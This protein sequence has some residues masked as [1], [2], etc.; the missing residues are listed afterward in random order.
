MKQICVHFLIILLIV[1]QSLFSFEREQD[2]PRM[3][4]NEQQLMLHFIQGKQFFKQSNYQKAK[5]EF[6]RVVEINSKYKPAYSYLERIQD[7][8]IEEMQS[9]QKRYSRMDRAMKMAE[10][11]ERSR[12]PTQVDLFYQLTNSEQRKLDAYVGDN[13]FSKMIQD[14]RLTVLNKAK[15]IKKDIDIVLQNRRQD[16]VM[17]SLSDQTKPFLVR[18][19]EE[20]IT[21]APGM[22]ERVAQVESVQEEVDLSFYYNRKKKIQ[23][24]YKRG[25]MYYKQRDFFEAKKHF[26]QVLKLEPGYK[27]AQDYYESSKSQLVLTEIQRRKAKKH[28]RKPGHLNRKIRMQEPIENVSERRMIEE[29][30]QVAKQMSRSFH[31]REGALLTGNK[32]KLIV[33]GITSYKNKDY[34][35][36]LDIFE[37]ILRFD[38]KDKKA[39]VYRQKILEI[40]NDKEDAVLEAMERARIAA[41]HEHIATQTDRRTLAHR[42]E[43]IHQ[44]D[45]VEEAVVDRK[46]RIIDL[47]AKGKTY[48]RKKKYMQALEYFRE[49]ELIDPTH[50]YVR[51]Y[52][53]RC[54]DI[55]NIKKENKALMSMNFDVMYKDGV[56][57]YKEGQYR[58][59]AKV[60]WDILRVDPEHRQAQKYLKHCLAKLKTDVRTLF[61]GNDSTNVLLSSSGVVTYGSSGI[62]PEAMYAQAKEFYRTGE[63]AQAIPLL[64]KVVKQRPNDRYAE[65]YLERS[66]KNLVSMEVS[67]GRTSSTEA[68]MIVPQIME[69]PKPIQVKKVD[70]ETVYEEGKSAYRKRDYKIAMRKFEQ[71]VLI[72]PDHHYA[73]RYLKRSKQKLLIFEGKKSA[74]TVSKPV[75]SDVS[76]KRPLA[77]HRTQREGFDDCYKQGKRLYLSGDYGGA[78]VQFEKAVAIDPNHRYASRYLK[79]SQKKL[80][81]KTPP[82]VFSGTQTVSEKPVPQERPKVQ[83]RRLVA[84]PVEYESTLAEEDF[85][86]LYEEAKQLYR[87]KNYIAAIKKFERVVQ[88]NPEHRYAGR[89]LTRA[90]EKSKTESTLKEKNKTESALPEEDF[91]VLYEEAKKLYRAKNYIVAIKKFERLVQLDPS[92]RYAGRYLTRAKEKSKMVPA[93]TLVVPETVV[94]NQMPQVSEEAL[95]RVY[96][97]AKVAYRAMEYAKAI[98]L[99]EKVVAG[100]L[101]YPYAERY[102]KRSREKLGAAKTIVS[103][104]DEMPKKDLPKLPMRE[105]PV[106]IK[107]RSKRKNITIK[108][109]PKQEIKDI[110]KGAVALYNQGYYASAEKILLRILKT[111]PKHKLS[112]HYLRFIRVKKAEKENGNLKNMSK[113][114]SKNLKEIYL[115]G[116]SLFKSL[117]YAQSLQVFKRALKIAP[118]NKT[119]LKALKATED[120][121]QSLKVPQV[122]VKPVKIKQVALGSDIFYKK[123]KELF[124]KKKY[125][126]AIPMFKEVVKI[127]PKHL[128]APKYLDKIRKEFE[129]LGQKMGNEQLSP[130]YVLF[131]HAATTKSVETLFEQ[132]KKLYEQKAY[133]DAMII[134]YQVSLLSPSHKYANKYRKRTRGFVNKETWAEEK[135]E[136]D[137][138]FSGSV[139]CRQVREEYP[140]KKK[141]QKRLGKWFVKVKTLFDRGNYA[142]AKVYLEKIKKKD[143]FYPSLHSY[144]TNI[145]LMMEIAVLEK[146][147]KPKEIEM[148]AKE[149]LK[150]QPK[151]KNALQYVSFGQIQAEYFKEEK[152]VEG[153]YQGELLKIQKEQ[154]FYDQIMKRFQEAKQLY[155]DGRYEKSLIAF[156]KILAEDSQNSYAKL[157]VDYAKQRIL[158]EKQ[159]DLE[160]RKVDQLQKSMTIENDLKLVLMKGGIIRQPVVDGELHPENSSMKMVMNAGLMRQ[161]VVDGELHPE[162]SSM[163]IIM[164]TDRSI[165][166]AKINTMIDQGKD[167]YHEGRYQDA[168]ILLKKV[169]ILDG[170]E[171][172]DEIQKYLEMSFKKVKEDV[173]VKPAFAKVLKEEKLLVQKK[174]LMEAGKGYFTKGE[175][176]L[177]VAQFKKV[178]A[179]DSSFEL[180]Q[181]YLDLSQ[182]KIN[183]YEQTE[184]K[185]LEQLTYQE[186]MEELF[187]EEKMIEVLFAKGKKHYDLNHFLLAKGFFEKVLIENPQYEL[188]QDYLSLVESHIDQKKMDE[189]KQLV[190]AHLEKLRDEKA[191]KIIKKR[192]QEEKRN[193]ENLQ[194]ISSQIQAGLKKG[195]SFYEVKDFNSA[196]SQ[197][198]QVLRIDPKNNLVFEYLN[199]AR[200]QLR[201][202]EKLSVSHL[203][204][205]KAKLL[206]KELSQIKSIEKVYHLAQSFYSQGDYEKA[207]AYFKY[208][209]VLDQNFS[210]MNNVQKHIE[211]I[212]NQSLSSNTEDVNYVEVL[213]RK[214][215]NSFIAEDW[216]VALGI[217]QNVSQIDSAYKSVEMYLEVVR[218]EVAKKKVA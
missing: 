43:S 104:R 37:Q 62:D 210:Y 90:K 2:I 207:L 196:I 107:K 82:A 136:I 151:H 137:S 38:S 171:R 142:R 61:A 170:L 189:E 108:A 187:Q 172:A 218:E 34:N 119:L 217:F 31:E 154:E 24:F 214:G 212:L 194:K 35:K 94:H 131:M 77:N 49:L 176:E 23:D 118:K 86:V 206:K 111:D 182:K 98:K 14:Q 1:T 140:L 36:A 17:T 60:F 48:Y 87:E 27:Y 50:R 156:Q 158:E 178:L 47:Y 122:V 166:M 8:R 53:R 192:E 169:W 80:A 199:L 74:E 101:K 185:R 117:E 106:F 92:H 11:K 46:V 59:A 56:A 65:R 180:A 44:T 58:V 81:E 109:L 91:K 19:F 21:E 147:G 51:K 143:P 216:E 128:F 67:G 159:L 57:L 73:S 191:A 41:Q 144:A 102:L 179:I 5:E 149:V 18:G 165:K 9:E 52:L 186:K 157:F 64:E 95:G 13:Q 201:A 78:I 134:F 153:K 129:K 10:T 127:N 83:K 100:A 195:K 146:D 12:K 16:D 89:Y 152:E 200:E 190:Q 123:G 148:K 25:I 75:V 3:F 208:V 202:Q 135:A 204:E 121:L 139:A 138:Y 213:Y 130:Y 141:E 22:N 72:K 184:M 32:K 125:R 150:T 124:R 115:E 84:M 116:L 45:T 99:F 162:N 15:G 7:V 69:N 6:L 54:E 183:Y 167:L 20:R 113:E 39:K 55:L 120:R 105:R 28:Y 177:A 168:I 188:A 193:I 88:L 160:L 68:T 63:F 203:K 30:G 155:E 97:Q 29:S 205:E 33:L 4:S 103:K 161:P 112:K 215:K 66:K 211:I 181:K 71:A 85:K 175:Y 173:S 79:H 145:R 163:K 26:E 174:N 198:E 96:E 197:F 40:M 76:F 114:M 164:N 126:E 133:R 209:W 93:V 42:A 110:F 132:G 70:F